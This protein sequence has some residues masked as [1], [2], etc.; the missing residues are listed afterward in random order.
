MLVVVA[1]PAAQLVQTLKVCC[2]LLH[3]FELC[4]EEGGWRVG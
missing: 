3:V 4:Q 1:A 2:G